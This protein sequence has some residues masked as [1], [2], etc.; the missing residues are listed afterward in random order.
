LWSTGARRRLHVAV[1]LDVALRVSAHFESE[2]RLV[3]ELQ[4]ELEHLVGGVGVEAV[5]AVLIFG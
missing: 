4:E 5:D 1:L 2:V 3:D